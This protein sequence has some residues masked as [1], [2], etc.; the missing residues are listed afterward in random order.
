MRWCSRVRE[1]VVQLEPRLIIMWFSAS[2]VQA[3]LGLTWAESNKIQAWASGCQ[4][5]KPAQA[6]GSGYSFVHMSCH[7]LASGEI[8]ISDSKNMHVF[9]Y[10]WWQW[11]VKFSLILALM[12]KITWLKT[13][14]PSQH[15]K[16]ICIHTRAWSCGL[17]L[18]KIKVW[19]LDSVK[20]SCITLC[21]AV[22]PT[23]MK[24]TTRFPLFNVIISTP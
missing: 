24:T 16:F 14:W 8:T 18:P 21:S 2:V 5:P 13:F 9:L 7:K 3:W 19:V 11:W 17:K 15:W 22:K 6:L 10:H 23:D 4:K 12:S 1:L 20:P